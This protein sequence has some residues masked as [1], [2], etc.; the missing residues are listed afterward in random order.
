MLEPGM[1]LMV[2]DELLDHLNDL[3]VQHSLDYGDEVEA[4]RVEPT[5]QFPV[6]IAP[7]HFP[8][9]SAAVH[10]TI[11]ERSRAF[12]EKQKELE[13]LGRGVSCPL[14]LAYWYEP[15]KWMLPAA[16]RQFW[17]KVRQNDP[18]ILA[19]IEAYQAESLG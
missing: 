9:F 5:G 6:V 18:A 19:E 4:M 16:R 17:E 7:F 12:Y 8:L 1:T 14:P 2:T 3:G 11:A 10:R 13:P 15:L